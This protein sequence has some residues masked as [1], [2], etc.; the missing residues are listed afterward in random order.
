[1]ARD[2]LMGVLLRVVQFGRRVG[3]NE[4]TYFLGCLR[5]YTHR[6]HPDSVVIKDAKERKC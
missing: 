4:G 2:G 5:P 3:M 1:M 6:L